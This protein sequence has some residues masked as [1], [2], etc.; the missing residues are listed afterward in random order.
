MEGRRQSREE[1]AS[2]EREAP[3]SNA[4]EHSTRVGKVKNGSHA[5]SVAYLF[6]V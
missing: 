6:K 3:Q 5:F 2:K 1:H 4:E